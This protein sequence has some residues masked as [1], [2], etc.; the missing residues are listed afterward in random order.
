MTLTWRSASTVD[1]VKRHAPLMPLL[2]DQTLNL[3]LRLM[4]LVDILSTG[5]RQPVHSFFPL[6]CIMIPNFSF[7]CRSFCMTKKSFLRME[8]VG[9]LRLQK[10]SDLKASTA[11]LPPRWSFLVKLLPFSWHFDYVEIKWSANGSW[12]YLYYDL[13]FDNLCCYSSNFRWKGIPNVR[14]KFLYVTF[15]ANEIFLG[16]HEK[17]WLI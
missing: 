8:T 5:Q 12:W 14:K 10:T 15:G 6:G 3:Q 9:R 16:V 11:D 4:R 2:K 13:W 1:F 17:M 7:C